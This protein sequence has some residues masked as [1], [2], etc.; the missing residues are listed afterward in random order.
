MTNPTLA[1]IVGSN[2][3]DSINRKLAQGIAKLAA[4]RFDVKFVQIDDLPMYNQDHE[5]DTPARGDALQ[6]RDQ[7]PTRSFSS[8]RSIT[9]RFR[10]F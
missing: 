3:R 8:R 7:R 1:V 5:A 10:P 6:E 9:A 2:R 4:G